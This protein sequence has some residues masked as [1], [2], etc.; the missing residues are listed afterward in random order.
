ML[1]RARNKPLVRYSTAL[2]CAL[3]ALL[4]EGCGMGRGAQRLS[5][6]APV[7]T[8]RMGGSSPAVLRSAMLSSG[9]AA[10]LN[11]RNFPEGGGF[12][13]AIHGEFNHATTF[14]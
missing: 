4:L 12:H 8:A 5:F 9:R 2:V 1:L 10:P 3:S 7:M 11:S 6:P 14:Y 13:V